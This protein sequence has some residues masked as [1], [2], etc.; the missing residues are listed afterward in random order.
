MNK[1]DLMLLIFC[2]VFGLV[3]MG[4][5]IIPIIIVAGRD[6]WTYALS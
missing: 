6:M 3:A 1:T 5:F 2:V 4:T